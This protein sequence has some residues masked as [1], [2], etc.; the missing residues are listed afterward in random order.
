MTYNP[1]DDFSD[2]LKTLLPLAPQE[3]RCEIEDIIDAYIDSRISDALD[4]EF[5]RGIYRY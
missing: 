4:R 2:L 5:N 3:K 1:A